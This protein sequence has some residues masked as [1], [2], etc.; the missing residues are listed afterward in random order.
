MS[1]SDITVSQCE[2]TFTSLSPA[3]LYLH[4]ESSDFNDFWT[5]LTFFLISES[6]S[7][8]KSFWAGWLYSSR[9]E[10]GT[11]AI[12]PRL[13]L[14]NKNSDFFLQFDAGAFML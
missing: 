4:P 3:I 8:K 12:K 5:I 2:R 7:L 9:I 10:Y 11:H 14:V 13:I 1:L 6:Q